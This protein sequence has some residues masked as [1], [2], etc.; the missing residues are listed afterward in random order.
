MRA[1][2]L[3]ALVLELQGR[4]EA[5]ISRI[6]DQAVGADDEAPVIDGPDNARTWLNS[7]RL[8]LGQALTREQAR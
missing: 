7:L 2:A 3:F 8:R 4:D 1:A 6:I 5:A